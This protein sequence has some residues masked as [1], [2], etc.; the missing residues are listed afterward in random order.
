MPEYSETI[1]FSSSS[2]FNRSYVEK[3]NKRKIAH[4]LYFTTYFVVFPQPIDFIEHE[5]VD[6]YY[7]V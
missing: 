1:L 2:C 3:L 6:I 5:C 4:M 7:V